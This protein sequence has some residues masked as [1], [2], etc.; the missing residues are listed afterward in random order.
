MIE[1]HLLIRLCII[2]LHGILFY[3]EYVRNEFGKQ[4]TLVHK[5]IES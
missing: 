3:T 1:H 2:I 5:V 4:I